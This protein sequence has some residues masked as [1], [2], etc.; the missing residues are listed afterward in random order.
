MQAHALLRRA[1]VAAAIIFAA[2]VS[3]QAVPLRANTAEAHTAK[4]FETARQQGPL[5]LHAFLAE[6]PKGG[7]LHNHLSGAVYAESWIADA[8]TDGLCVDISTS[9]LIDKHDASAPN[10]GTGRRPAAD[11]LSDQHFYDTL[12]DAFSMRSFVPANGHSG[13]DQ[14]F[15]SFRRFDAVTP[16]LHM[17]DWLNEVSTRAAAQNEQYL[18]LMV[19][20]P[21]AHA[22]ELARTLGWHDD[23]DVMRKQLLAHGLKDEIATDEQLLTQALAERKRQQHCDSA[24]A[25]AA[26]TMQIRFLYQ[27]LRG[28]PPER[29][30]AQTLLGFE[31]ASVDPRWVG[32]NFVMPE[33]GYLSM[34]DY[35]LQMRM[36][37]YLHRLYPTVH[38]SLHAGELAPGLVPPDGLRFH[39]RQAVEIGHAERI[40][41]GVDVMYEDRPEQL[42]EEMAKRHVMVEI[43]LT[44]NDV[45]L[46]V[47]GADHPLPIYLK[48]GV[49]VALS[50]DDEGVSRIDLTHEYV[51]AAED[52]S[53]DYPTLKQMARNSLTYSFLPGESLWTSKGCQGQPLGSDHPNA[54]C[55]QLLSDSEKAAAQ[56]ELE[57]RLSAFERAH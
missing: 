16:Q 28:A 23:F 52:F 24:Q 50:T 31:L 7:D 32:I 3:A 39:I 53:L 4:A 43:N 55:R 37:D 57:R 44:S 38:I 21:F 35:T 15:D 29:V 8:A 30:F 9:S 41:H 19:T 45:I 18:E 47:R 40:G 5:A 36:L 48:H 14:F 51:R 54:I 17:G 11:A 49:P 33:D 2:Q 34:R 25:D 20:P 46:G 10:C 22:R 1:I 6:M 26:C 42:L 13:H 27:V 56:W 12:V